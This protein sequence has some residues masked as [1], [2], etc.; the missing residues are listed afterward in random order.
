MKKTFIVLI[1]LFLTFNLVYSQDFKKI[2]ELSKQLMEKYHLPGIAIVG[3]KN[4]KIVYKFTSGK[5]NEDYDLSESSRIYIASNTKAFT[6]LALSKLAYENKINFSDPVSKYIPSSYF[7]ANIEIN[8]ITVRQLMQHT[9]GLSNDPLV[10]RTAYS[11]EYPSDLKELL[12][13]TVYR[14]DSLSNEFHY[15]NLGYILGGIIIEQVTGKNWREY[16]TDNILKKIGMINSTAHMDFSSEEETLPFKY[17]S[18]VHLTSR[19]SENT[20]HAAGGIYSTLDNMSKWLALYTFNSPVPIGPKLLKLYL[21]DRVKVNKSMGP[22]SMDE[23][24]NGWI[25][26][27]LM[28]NKLFFHFGSFYGYESMMSFQ[29]GQNDGVFVFVNEITGGQRIA[30]MITAYF[31]LIMSN[32][33]DA[34]SKIKMF[35]QFIDPL[36]KEDNA[37]RK[38]F[39]FENSEKITGKYYSPEYGNLIVDKNTSGYTFRIGKLESIAY[40][41]EKE[42]EMIIEFTPGIKEH[43]FITEDSGKTKLIYGDFGTFLKR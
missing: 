34:D 29:P 26:G 5:A 20:L 3:V 24:G 25:S 36:Y 31:Y 21:N 11:G 14:L 1:L 10:F 9:H 7:P 35:T 30:A 27:S 40:A 32:D 43:F 6:G 15:S 23:Y 16:I 33:T 19:K 13:F 4:G 38:I 42:N 28:G 18:D 37:E 22:L 8:K 41:G 17:N 12:K 39:T 2:D